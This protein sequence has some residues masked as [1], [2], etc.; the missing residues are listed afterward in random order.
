MVADAISRPN[1]V[2]GAEWTLHQVF[3]WLR[4]RW[5]VTIDLF[6][7]SLNHRCGVYFAPM[8]DPMAVGMDVMLQPWDFLQAYTFPP[9]AMIPQV[10]VKLRSSPGMV[11]TLIAPFLP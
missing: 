5:P 7:F 8:S 4:K 2:I 6:A 1:Q 9:F 11:L 10:L 3:D